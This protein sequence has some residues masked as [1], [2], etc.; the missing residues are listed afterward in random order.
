MKGYTKKTPERFE[1]AMAR[2][3]RRQK[4]LVMGEYVMNLA[5]RAERGATVQ[6]VAA[7]LRE[8]AAGKGLRNGQGVPHVVRRTLRKLADQLEAKPGPITLGTPRALEA[9][10]QILEETKGDS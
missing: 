4:T 8:Q 10:L 1:L 3:C 2:V 5:L 7:W 9:G 6:D